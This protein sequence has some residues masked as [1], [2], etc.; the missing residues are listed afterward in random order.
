MS[1]MLD[2]FAIQDAS[3]VF[4]HKDQMNM[5]RDN[6]VPTAS[7][8]VDIRHR[9]DYAGILLRRQGYK[10]AL[11]R[12]NGE[13]IRNM[14]RFAGARRFVFNKALA[15]NNERYALVGRTRWCEGA[16]W[17]ADSGYGAGW[18][19]SY[20]TSHLPFLGKPG[21]LP[22]EPSQPAAIKAVA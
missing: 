16:L 11:L 2:R 17:T 15:L 8:V 19:P 18:I 10:F 1:Q 9:P 21:V 4:R 7:E 3:A 22:D 13:Q 6:Y 20:F 14:R 5:H 12:P